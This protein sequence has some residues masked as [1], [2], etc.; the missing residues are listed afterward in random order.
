M[1]T[2]LRI[3]A[4]DGSPIIG[5]TMEFPT[6]MDA[7]LTVI[8][9]EKALASTAPNNQA[10]H[11]W[12]TQYGVVGIDAFPQVLPGGN[13]SYTDG[14]NEKGV[15]GGLLYHPGFCVLA[16]G[17]SAPN[18]QL[19]NPL[20]VIAYVL[21]TC[22]N[23]A[24][25]KTALSEVTVWDYTPP[26]PVPLDV[27]FR[28]DDPTGA[29]V[30]VEWHEGAM[31]IFDNPIGVMTNSP[32]FDWHLTN[33]R[34][35]INLTPLP[36]TQQTING[37]T[38]APLGIGTSMR[39]LPGDPTPPARFVRAVALSATAKQTANA[40]EGENMMLH[41]INN[42]DLP[43]GVAIAQVDP[44][45][46]DQTLWSTISNLREAS[47]SVRTQADS[48]FRKITMA[49]VDFSAADI[50]EHD[51]PGASGFPAWTL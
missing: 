22:A 7:Q 35:Y 42:F 1:C 20:H 8:P 19:L 12:T 2:S 6:L 36:V 51:L 29:S 27:H 48:T 9:R 24:E 37:V 45:T 3:S 33:L 11:K 10:G 39:G 5:R 43:D 23:V 18:E 49:D 13:F 15:Y 46:E 31:R 44:P 47:F 16:P 21:S 40:A 28:F 34:N 14:M 4:K 26:I 17:N 38:L 25:V 30:V 32:N 50:T 41:L